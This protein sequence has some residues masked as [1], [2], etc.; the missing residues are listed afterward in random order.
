MFIGGAAGF[1]CALAMPVASELIPENKNKYMN[2]SFQFD[3]VLLQTVR[4]PAPTHL[5][6]P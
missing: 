6:F 5:Y 4:E 3:M 2:K 1:S